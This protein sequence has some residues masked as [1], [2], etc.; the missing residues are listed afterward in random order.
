MNTGF[1][2]PFRKVPLMAPHTPPWVTIA[3][4]R[5]NLPPQSC[6]CGNRYCQRTRKGT[7]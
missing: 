5:T 4:S 2:S 6:G 1:R 7:S 3:V